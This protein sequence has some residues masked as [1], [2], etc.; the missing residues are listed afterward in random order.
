MMVIDSQDATVDARSKCGRVSPMNDR[1]SRLLF[2]VDED[3]DFCTHR[4]DLARAARRAGFDIVVATHVQRHAKQI[5][6]EGFT[7]R[8]IRLRR[9][10]QS[11]MRDAVALMELI[12][13]YRVEQPD[14][15]HH[16]ALKQVLF[17][18]IAARIAAV[19]SV[20][21]AITGLGYMFQ[22][23]SWRR[24][25]LRSMISPVLRWGL[26]HPRSAVIF[27]NPDD[28]DDLVAARIVHNSRAVIIRGAGVN[29][30]Q[31]SPSPEPAGVPVVVLASRMLRDKGVEE[32]VKAARMLKDTGFQ[33]RCVLVGM[34]DAD[35]PS[36]FTDAELQRWQQEG[37]VEWWGH[38]DNMAEVFASSHIVVLPS[39]GEGLP[40]VLLE[41][42]ACARPLIATDVRGCREIVRE[43]ESGL[44]VP[45]KDPDALAHAILTLVADSALRD[46]MGRRAR[47]IVVNEYRV[48]RIA[49]QTIALYHRL[50]ATG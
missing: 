5:E 22:S 37:M 43:G 19:P 26:A 34:V 47:E 31:F 11:P 10:V 39:Y 8:P 48:E 50:L 9:G 13:L 18:S 38:R 21:N 17:G 15:V 29:I 49:G 40:K 44:L 2:V 33:A 32:F 35:N 16:V 25:C 42:A 28:R 46:R 30:E 6:D 45:A 36:S 1:R 41:A 20:V 4:L 12:R 14:I 24:S 27:Q 3:R 7:L 23:G